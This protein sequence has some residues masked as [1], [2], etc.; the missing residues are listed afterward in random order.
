MKIYRFYHTSS[1]CI[2]E[3]EKNNLSSS[4]HA[5]CKAFWPQALFNT[6]QEL[7]MA[8]I[9]DLECIYRNISMI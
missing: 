8:F 2:N 7:L 9:S 3:N 6:T 5:L 4:A 1:N